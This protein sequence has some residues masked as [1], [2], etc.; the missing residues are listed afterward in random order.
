MYVLT[1]RETETRTE[2]ERQTD[3]RHRQNTIFKGRKEKPREM[4]TFL[5]KL[6]MKPNQPK[7]DAKLWENRV[8]KV[9]EK[10]RQR[11]QALDPL[12]CG[13]PL[14]PQGCLRG[15]WERA[16]ASKLAPLMWLINTG[17]RMGKGCKNGVQYYLRFQD[18]FL[19]HSNSRLLMLCDLWS[20]M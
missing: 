20:Y 4:E 19:K 1:H 9:K 11:R 18:Q 3:G 8:V 12:Q 17:R 6:V 14:K 5:L 2:M 15:L 10:E 16:H 7:D 13:A